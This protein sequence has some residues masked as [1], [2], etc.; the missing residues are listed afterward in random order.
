MG[1]FPGSLELSCDLTADFM[2]LLK[3]FTSERITSFVD[4]LLALLMVHFWF[5]FE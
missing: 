4:G 5:W 3:G 1:N 2:L